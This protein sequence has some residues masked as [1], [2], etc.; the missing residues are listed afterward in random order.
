M[1]HVKPYP[2]L[3]T[4]GTYAVRFSDREGKVRN[5]SFGCR[6]ESEAAKVARKISL[7]LD[8][9]AACEPLTKEAAD[10]LSA[11]PAAWRAKL[12]GL[13]VIDGARAAALD[14]LSQHIEAWADTIRPQKPRR[15]DDVLPVLR[16][17]TAAAKVSRLNE[18]TLRTADRVFGQMVVDEVAPTTIRKHQQIIKQ[19]CTWAVRQG[20][21]TVNPIAEMQGVSGGVE[22]ERR[23]LDLDEQRALL[24]FTATAPDQ[25]WRTRSGTIRDRITGPERAMLYRVA[26]ETGLRAG[27]LRSLTRDSF[28]LARV[29]NGKPAPCIQL[30]AKDEKNRKGSTLPLRPAT[31]AL[32]A[33]FIARKLPGTR[34]FPMPKPDETA[35]MIRRDLAGARDTWIQQAQAD[36]RQEREESTYLRET[37]ESG[38]GFDFHAL[39]VTFITNMARAGVPVQMAVKLARHSD[40]KLTI[41]IYTKAGAMDT[42]DAIDQL[43]D[44]DTPAKTKATGTHG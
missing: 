12:T 32:I 23:A 31:A 19:F 22:R 30:R 1:K 21:I 3:C 2:V 8:A 5:F 38:A 16:S 37:D 41:G 17:F 4:G 27:E 34:V 43:P 35:E 18:I 24:D 28:K 7:I 29:V 14:P 33:D 40:P 36:E 11:I 39:R 42:A 26:L 15:A 13:G 6:S 10:W 25:V 20:L 9:A 44:L